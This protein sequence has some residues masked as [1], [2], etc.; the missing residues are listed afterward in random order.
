[1]LASRLELDTFDRHLLLDRFHS[2]RS[3]QLDIVMP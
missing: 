1:M 2:N 3:S